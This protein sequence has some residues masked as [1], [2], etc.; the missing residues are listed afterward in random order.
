MPGYLKIVATSTWHNRPSV[1]LPFLLPEYASDDV[2]YL[3]VR[4]PCLVL[5]L[6]M[7]CPCLVHAF[8]LKCTLAG[9]SRTK[10]VAS[11]CHVGVK[12]CPVVHQ[13]LFPHLIRIQLRK[14]SLDASSVLRCLQAPG[15]TYDVAQLLTR[16]HRPSTQHATVAMGS[17]QVTLCSEAAVRIH[18]YNNICSVRVWAR[19]RFPGFMEPTKALSLSLAPFCHWQLSQSHATR[20]APAMG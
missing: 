18:G 3:N 14:P 8:L 5:A 13:I 1:D 10:A 20:Y 19:L 15:M 6:S 9:S 4:L 17:V 11:K 2:V 16:K 12:L 7:P